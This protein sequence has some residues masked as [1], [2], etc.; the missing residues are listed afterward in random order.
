MAL[1]MIADWACVLNRA[2][3]QKASRG[4]GITSDRMFGYALSESE[5]LFFLD[6]SL[7]RK[8]GN[9]RER[10][11]K[12]YD[13]RTKCSNWLTLTCICG[14][15]LWK[16]SLSFRPSSSSKIFPIL[17]RMHLRLNLNGP[18]KTHHKFFN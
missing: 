3:C 16:K 7:N 5:I 11:K 14:S 1:L 17:W 9:G 6:N 10:V 12:W 4:K 8:E 13:Q 15:D 2:R 18:S